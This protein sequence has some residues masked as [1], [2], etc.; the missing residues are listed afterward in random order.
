MQMLNGFSNILL[1]CIHIDIMNY[2]RYSC[3]LWELC[4]KVLYILTTKPRINI[5]PKFD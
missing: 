5:S 2:S 1:N 4:L 3:E